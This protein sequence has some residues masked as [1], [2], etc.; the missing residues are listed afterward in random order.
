M[1]SLRNSFYEATITPIL[2]PDKDIT[3]KE[4]YRPISLININ[5]ISNSYRE[6][7]CISFPLPLFSGLKIFLIIFKQKFKL[8]SL[9]LIT[10]FIELLNTG[11][12]SSLCPSVLALL[13]I[14]FLAAV[15]LFGLVGLGCL[16]SKLV[17]FQV[18]CP[19]S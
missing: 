16:K 14:V 3:K 10:F 2:K 6:L 9:L 11:I 13:F 15:I 4:N 8:L 7:S 19:L 17:V 18:E 12:F 5:A 1:V